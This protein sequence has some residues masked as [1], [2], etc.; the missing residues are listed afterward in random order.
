MY[1]VYCSIRYFVKEDNTTILLHMEWKGAVEMTSA[2][3][4]AKQQL[5]NNEIA[6][7]N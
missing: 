7:R 6:R 1:H 3:N 4:A 5:L 2:W